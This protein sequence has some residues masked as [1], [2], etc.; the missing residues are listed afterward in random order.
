MTFHENRLFGNVA[1]GSDT[2]AKQDISKIKS[3]EIRE[4]KSVIF[5][6][7]AEGALGH[8]PVYNFKKD[9]TETNKTLQYKCLE[10]NENIWDAFKDQAY[11]QL[12]D[13]TFILII[14]FTI[15][16]S[17]WHLDLERPVTKVDEKDET[18]KESTEAK[19]ESL[20]Q[21]EVDNNDDDAF[22]A[23]K[24]SINEGGDFEDEDLAKLI[25]RKKAPTRQ[26]NIHIHPL[27]IYISATIG[28]MLVNIC[29]IFLQNNVYANE[30]RL[31]VSIFIVVFLLH[32]MYNICRSHLEW[33]TEFEEIEEEH[34]ENINKMR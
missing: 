24:S 2:T 22:D 7:F 16:W 4:S 18:P 12:G 21:P 25:V 19:I 30:T 27:R 29:S 20:R 32:Y 14:I 28:L 11:N 23:F 13:K 26:K 9:C 33:E 3:K 15:S 8:M 17:N 1:K 34:K 31:T 5:H 10:L 6:D